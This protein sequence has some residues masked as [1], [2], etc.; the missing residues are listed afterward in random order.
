MNN[1]K[2]I[3]DGNVNTL[4]QQ[5]QLADDNLAKAQTA[6]DALKAQ[7]N[8]A[9][10]AFNIAKQA[11]DQARAAKQ[12]A[13]N[14]LNNVVANGGNTPYPYI[15]G[16]GYLGTG[17]GTTSNGYPLNQ[18]ASFTV[19]TAGFSTGSYPGQTG[20]NQGGF[21]GSGNQGN[22][23]YS[24]TTTTTTTTYGSGASE[25]GFGTGSGA[26]GANLVGAGNQGLIT[27]SANTANLGA[28]QNV[29]LINGV[30]GSAGASGSSIRGTGAG[31]LGFGNLGNLGLGNLGG[32][33]GLGYGL[34]S[35]ST[36]GSGS[37][38]G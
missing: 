28:P 22:N 38:C 8:N 9:T 11:Y 32:N 37:G 1:N 24:Q 2:N 25:S 3:L 27:G 4:R 31:A 15:P 30:A 21:P 13:D 29:V 14:A 16:S 36:G 18:A 34:T 5:Q 23:Q 20:G 33:L 17:L 7:L 10:T 19:N 12:A 6:A 26:A 35:I